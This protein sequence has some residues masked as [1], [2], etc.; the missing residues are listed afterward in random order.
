MSLVNKASQFD[1]AILV[2]S[3][4]DEVQSKGECKLGPRDNAIFELGLFIGRLGRERTFVVSNAAI[5]IP[6]DLAGV[7][8]ATYEWPRQDNTLAGAVGHACDQIR[9]E[10]RRL[11]FSRER[12][13]RQIQ[14]VAQE[15]QRQAG[16]INVIK[17]MLTLV[18]PEYERQHLVGLAKSDG[19]FMVE[20]HRDSSAIF[21]SELQH[22]VSLQLVEIVEHRHLG[23][24]FKNEGM[25]DLKEF[26]R[27]RDRGKEYLEVYR[28]IQ[29]IGT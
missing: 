22:L 13:T 7:V 2:L 3:P 14:Q 29:E 27:I 9:V 12:S 11:G 25:R 19:T 8:F 21:Q 4:D 28:R 15:Q 10:I 16:E 20:I 26:L 17:L 1:F 24:L 6:T 5:K 23:D 18:L